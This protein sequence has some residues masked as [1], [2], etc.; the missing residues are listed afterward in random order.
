MAAT[1]RTA[2]IIDVLR[3]AFAPLMLGRSGRLPGQVPQDGP[4]TR[5]R[6]T[7]AL[8]A[9]STTTS[10]PRPTTGRAT[11]QSGIWIQRVV[12]HVENFGTYLNSD[13]RLV[14]DINDFDEAYLGRFTWDLQR[15]AASLALVAWQKALPE[16]AIR[17][18][19]ARYAR[20]YL[21]QV[22]HYVASDSDDDFEITLDT[23]HGPV[24]IA[25]EEA[26]AMRRA[27]LLDGMTVM[28]R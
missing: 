28:D 5:T 13:G 25:L 27:D 15:F 24:L 23:A 16:D 14:F 12:L 8:R 20:S 7:A 1:D 17:K 19:I 2:V 18:L 11:A 21:A 6:S 10:R 9:C 22:N 4:L 3:D 26:R